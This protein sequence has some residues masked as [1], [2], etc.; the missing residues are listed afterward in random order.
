MKMEIEERVGRHLPLVFVLALLLQ[1][2]SAVWWVSAKDRDTFFLEQRVNALEA[3]FAHAS[4]AQGQ[5]LERLA[6][7]EERVNAQFNLLDRIEKHLSPL[8]K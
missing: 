1:G 5:T 7:I 3:G 4:E 2:A 8:G 6:R